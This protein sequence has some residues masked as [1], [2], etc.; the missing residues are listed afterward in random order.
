MQQMLRQAPVPRGPAG[1]L[2]APLI[3]LLL[4]LLQAFA[5]GLAQLA[6][7]IEVGTFSH[8]PEAPPQATEHPRPRRATVK[9]E[10]TRHTP[11]AASRRAR[12]PAPRPAPARANRHPAPRPTPGPLQ[13]ATRKAP[14]PH[15]P[16]LA[17]IA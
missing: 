1:W 14:R 10:T 15:P 13:A 6:A 3:L 8:Q 12:R 2:A 16:P 9:P 5:D 4:Q 17:K 11:A 7:R